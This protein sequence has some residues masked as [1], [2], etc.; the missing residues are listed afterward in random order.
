MKDVYP[1]AYL[2]DSFPSLDLLPDFLARWR[3]TARANHV[4]ELELYS[5][6]ALEVKERMARGENVPDCLVLRLWQSQKETQLDLEE[7]SYMAFEAGT[8]TTAATLQW[9]FAAMILYPNVLAKAQAE[10]DGYTNSST[11]M[12]PTFANMD[13]L[14]YCSA[15]VKEVFRWAPAAPGGVPHYSD[16]DDDYLGYRI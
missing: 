2:V 4:K 7:I 5:S 9:F 15:L 6:L 13:N 10:I 3:F 11:N 8:D 16:A 14:P 1:G 12:P